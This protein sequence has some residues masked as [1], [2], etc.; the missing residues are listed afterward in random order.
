MIYCLVNFAEVVGLVNLV[1]ENE[2]AD[3]GVHVG[4]EAVLI[5]SYG[6]PLK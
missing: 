4:I 2:F 1:E 5:D 3:L 6:V